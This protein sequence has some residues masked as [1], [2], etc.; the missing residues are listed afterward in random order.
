MILFLYQIL[1]IF[2]ALVI[3]WNMFKSDKNQEKVLYSFLIIPLLLR[4][5]LIK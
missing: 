3:I 5:F 2:V 4:A 1:C